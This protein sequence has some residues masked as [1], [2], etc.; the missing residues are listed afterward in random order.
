[1][2]KTNHSCPPM[3]ENNKAPASRK[4]LASIIGVGLTTLLGAC[5]G[6][7]MPAQT[8]SQTVISSSVFDSS[9]PASISSS[10]ESSLAESSSSTLPSSASTPLSSSSEASSQSSA[11]DIN[12]VTIQ[13]NQAGFCYVNGVIE[14]QHMGFEGA[15]YANGD[16]EEGTQIRWYIEAMANQNVEIEI[17]YANGGDAGRDAALNINDGNSATITFEASAWDDWQ[18][19]TVN[20]NVEAGGNQIT[21]TSRSADGLANIDSITI[22]G[23]GINTGECPLPPPE[24]IAVSESRWFALQNRTNDLVMAIQNNADSEGAALVQAAR[25]DSEN[26]QFRFES[27]GDNYYRLIARH[28]EL[29]LD[30]FEANPDDGADLVQWPAN[31][32][33]NQEFQALDLQNGFIHLVNRLSEKAL[34]PESNSPVAGSRI[35]QY[36]RSTEAAQQ[37]QLIDIAPYSNNQPPDAADCGAGTPDA[38]VTGGPGR[39]SVNGSNVGG[40]YYEAISRAINSLNNNRSSQERVT[41]MADGDIGDNWIDLPSNIIFEVCGTMNVGFARGR[42]AV[43]AIGK[44]NVSIPFLKMTGSPWF[45]FRFAGMRNLHLG[46]IEIIFD[47]GTGAMGIRFERDLDP[48]YDVTMDYIHVENTGNHGVETW[49]IDGLKIGTVIARNIAYAGLLLNNTRNAEVGLVDGE[50]TGN[51]TGYATLR[52][53]NTNGRIGGG[54]PTNIYVD[55]VISRGGGRG[56]FCVS[57]SGGAVINHVDLADNG[58]NAIL[59]ENCHNITINGGTVNG[60]GE[61]RI[62]ARDAFPNTSDVTISDLEVR[63]ND[64]RE[65]P[66]GDNVSWPGLSVSGGSDNTCN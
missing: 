46:N 19:A 43:S 61:V 13:E 32:R 9:S 28:S 26:Q 44:R 10:S 36:E 48:S 23:I 56:F 52:F 21:L 62:A 58:N 18:V 53:A 5:T 45:G 8:S 65:S 60:G 51:G 27:T 63:N 3:G 38:I 59:I 34:T 47:R 55:R 14:S 49:N 25:G 41:V 2:T 15:G 40:N 6:N 37:W 31:G 20:A 54:W 50:N 12:P 22:N 11:P 33:Q 42:G 30:L 39:Y 35:T 24:P 57:N 7:D 4:A 16:N 66:C 1:M 29:A 17:R 64:V